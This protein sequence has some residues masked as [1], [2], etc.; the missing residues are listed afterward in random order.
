MERLKRPLEKK[1]S[2]PIKQIKE[3]LK[4]TEYDLKAEKFLRETKTEFESVFKRYG[5][6]FDDETDFRDIY[7]ITLKRGD[8]VFK[9]DFGQSINASRKCRIYPSLPRTQMIFKNKLEEGEAY[10]LTNNKEL[11]NKSTL[12]GK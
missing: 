4:K 3:Q 11:I 12:W 6:H 1:M 8:R 10:C 7:E 9:F 5:K 2:K